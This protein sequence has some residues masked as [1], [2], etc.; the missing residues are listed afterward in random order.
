MTEP[1]AVTEP[2]AV[3]EPVAEAEPLVEAETE[4]VV[5]EPEAP[6]VPRRRRATR[7]QGAPTA[8]DPQAAP[9]AD[10]QGEPVPAS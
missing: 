6:K 1:V 10:P 8:A 3:V 2:A 5:P 9:A 7:Q 4:T